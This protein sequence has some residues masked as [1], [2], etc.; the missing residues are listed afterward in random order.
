[1]ALL[2]CD[3]ECF[4]V[5]FHCVGLVNCMNGMYTTPNLA[6]YVQKKYN[7]KFVPVFYESNVLP[8]PEEV[9]VSKETMNINLQTQNDNEGSKYSTNNDLKSETSDFDSNQS[10]ND[11]HEGDFH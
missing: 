4:K 5:L 9:E 3:Y 1:M 2:V 11:Y 6:S 8:T 7:G 10:D